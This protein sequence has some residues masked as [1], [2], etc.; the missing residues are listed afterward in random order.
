MPWKK[1]LWKVEYRELYH[2][3]SALRKE[4]K[5]IRQGS[6]KVLYANGRTFVYARFLGKD[7][8]VI[9]LSQEESHSV[10]SIPLALV[11]VIEGQ[12]QD[13]LNSGCTHYVSEGRMILP[14]AAGETKVLTITD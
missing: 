8:V 2:S 3:L 12:F 9:A 14:L 5:A 6:Y 10:H 4:S 1:S 11:G 7:V 13:R